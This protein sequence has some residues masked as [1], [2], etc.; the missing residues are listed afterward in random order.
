MQQRPSNFAYVLLVL[1]SI[2]SMGGPFMIG[3]IL[4]GGEQTRWPPDRP[5]EWVIVIAVTGT[6]VVL[7]ATILIHGF[8]LKR[9]FARQLAETKKNAVS[10]AVGADGA[11]S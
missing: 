1:M 7:M 10:E 6:V 5:V 3:W 4:K 11:T 2:S 9:Q 8:R